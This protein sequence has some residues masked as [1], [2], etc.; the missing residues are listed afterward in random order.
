MNRIL[1][2]LFL[3]LPFVTKGQT[4]PPQNMGAKFY[5]FKNGAGMDSALF[6]PRRDTNITDATMRSAGM[7]LYRPLDSLL[8]YMK[9]N[10]MTPVASGNADLSNYYTKIQSD[11]RFVHYSDTTAMLASRWD[12]TTIKANF[13]IDTVANIPA[14]QSY[15]GNA[16]VLLVKE[17][18]RGGFFYA[19]STGAIDNIITF[20]DG[21]GRY[22]IRSFNPSQGIS[23]DWSGADPTGTT[24]AKALIQSTFALPYKKFYFNPAGRYRLDDSVRIAIKDSIL[25]DFNGATIYENTV[26]SYTIVF[27]GCNALTVR[28]GNFDGTQTYASFQANPISFRTYIQIDSC[29]NAVVEGIRSKNKQGA[30]AFRKAYKFYANNIDHIGFFDNTHTT[31]ASLAPAI[32]VA[33]DGFDTVTGWNGYNVISNVHSRNSGSTVLLGDDAQLYT[34]SNIRGENLFDNGVYISS[35]LYA[36]VTGCVFRYV[37]GSGVKAR[38]RG[39]TIVGNVVTNSGNGIVATGNNSD[40]FFGPIPDD[41]GGNGY[42]TIISNNVIDSVTLKGISLEAQDG[43]TQ[44]DVTV[45]NNTISHHINATNSALQVST[46]AATTING[47]KIYGSTASTAVIVNNKAGDSTQHLIFANNI[48]HGCTGIGVTFSNVKKSVIEGNRFFDVTGN[49]MLFQSCRGNQVVNNYS[50]GLIYNASAAN[51]NFSNVFMLNRGSSATTDNANNG[52]LWNLPNTQ[53]GITNRPWFQGSTAISTSIP[54]I[55]LD[56]VSSANWARLSL[57]YSLNGLTAATQTFATGTSGTDFGITSTTSTHTFNLPTASAT[58]RGALSSTDWSTF[59]NKAPATGGTGYIQNQSAGAQTSS[60]FWISG[61]GRVAGTM[62]F[63][64]QV[65][66]NGLLNNGSG[67]ARLGVGNS[68]GYFGTA[69]N[70]GGADGGFLQWNPAGT[71]AN[72]VNIT[73][74]LSAPLQK[75]VL[76]GDSISVLNGSGTSKLYTNGNLTWNAGNDGAG[77]GLDAD[78]LDGLSSGV[79]A[80]ADGSTNSYIKN[81]TSVQ[82]GN[83]HINGTAKITQSNPTFTLADGVNS[84]IV[85][86]MT[87]GRLDFSNQNATTSFTGTANVAIGASTANSKLDVTGALG[88]PLTITG[89]NLTLSNSHHTIRATASGITLTFPAASSCPGRVYV[90][91]NYNTGGNITTSAFLTS[92]AVSTTTIATATTVWVQSDG[93]NWYKIN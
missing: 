14:L 6:L 16:K 66:A 27:Y 33:H 41:L 69:S 86:Q 82:T 92:G 83:W 5:L 89:T 43:F 50:D 85:M 91:I 3:L 46:T 38:G 29:T 67:T 25:V 47:N 78:L 4:Y 53:Q 60:S 70:A 15:T 31:N 42:G 51:S 49:A 73:G 23:I 77:S 11:G 79:F 57:F 59:N 52:V 30:V 90:I 45:S 9:G 12:S 18:L 65:N 19:T 34:I 87:G 10:T 39:F 56:T 26:R 76:Y 20:T 84:D 58:N 1:A 55:A 8:Y 35:A 68:N 61:T 13:P 63:D 81:T 28:N 80:M 40:T 2:I 36:T 74:V 37:S 24:D 17:P 62:T 71:A 93:T 75:I 21:N 22:M 88:L 64:A 32:Y 54:Y 48:F 7:I 72:I 44:H